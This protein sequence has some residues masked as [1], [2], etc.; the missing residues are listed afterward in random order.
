MSSIFTSLL[1]HFQNVP[2]NLSTSH[3]SGESLEDSYDTVSCRP[4][5]SL[6]S[7]CLCCMCLIARVTYIVCDLVYTCKSS[8]KS[9]SNTISPTLFVVLCSW[10]RETYI[11]QHHRGSRN[12]LCHILIKVSLR[13]EDLLQQTTCME[14]VC[15]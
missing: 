9:G 2:L 11:T 13:R 15:F 6:P 7:Y 10:R 1:V 8:R 3:S 12:C 5:H 14:Q 4:W